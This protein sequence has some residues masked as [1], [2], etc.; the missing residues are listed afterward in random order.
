MGQSMQDEALSVEYVPAGHPEHAADL[1][2]EKVPALQAV[3]LEDSF[4]E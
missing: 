3:Q 2:R 4:I 1:P